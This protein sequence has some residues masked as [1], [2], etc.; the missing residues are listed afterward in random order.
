MTGKKGTEEAFRAGIIEDR[1]PWGSFRRYPHADAGAIKIITVE[2][3]GVLS[4]QLHEKRAEFWVL[5]DLGLEMTLGER[6]WRPA[7]GDEV[8]IP[9]RTPHR[10]R[11]IGKAPARIMEI[12]I[13]KSEESDIV[14]LE[15]E[16]G[17]R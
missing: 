7:P 16:Y 9:R 11:N 10:V 17:R 8:F 6:V 14:R 15:D 5:L 4:L 2:P 13:G 12:W 1:R 3:G